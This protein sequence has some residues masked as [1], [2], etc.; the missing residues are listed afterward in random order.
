MI[1]RAV[2]PASDTAGQT[3]SVRSGGP[4]LGRPGTWLS[5]RGPLRLRLVAAAVCLVVAG[6]AAIG[7]AGVLVARDSLMAQA[8]AQLRA[9][10]ATLVSRQFTA[11]PASRLA[12]GPDGPGSGGFS[13]EV[14]NSAG[15][16]VLKIGRIPAVAGTVV[17]GGRLTT[18]SAGRGG[19]RWIVIAEP[20]RYRAQRIL[21]TYGYDDF[22][23]SITGPDRAG[24]AGRLLVGLDLSGVDRVIGRFA[25]ACLAISGVAALAVAIL[26]AMGVGALLR[27]LATM[28]ER[29]GAAA[30]AGGFSCR[31]P[32]RDARDDAGRLT[33]SLNSMLGQLE[34]RFSAS[35]ESEAAARM[36][37]RQL[38]H[39]IVDTG[40][41]LQRPLGVI[42]G[43]ADRH[44]EQARLSTG[45]L[46]RMMR[47]VAAE[48]TRVD[49]L[50]D[51]LFH[52]GRHQPGPPRQ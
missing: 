15:Q 29:I 14:L 48:A 3:G 13:M 4:G 49:S 22:S 34:R 32:A 44:R 52:A 8:D 23:V 46:D 30:K 37:A 17:A 26:G 28:E 39:H 45:E 12:P 10:A 6:G 50:I 36:S 24:D 9:Y 35:A 7:S 18:V 47:R 21:F 42:R 33:R 1:G 25:L 11:T 40:H 16:P 2:W 43:L 51:D 41:K 19:G 5:G 31:V 38:S 20:V 27:P